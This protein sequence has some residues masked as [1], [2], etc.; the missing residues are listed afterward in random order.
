MHSTPIVQIATTL[1]D[2]ELWGTLG[3]ADIKFRYRRTVIGPFWLTI[4]TGIIV[5]AI[6]LLYAAL[7][8]KDISTYIPFFAIGMIFWQFLSTGMTE[9]CSVFINA[10]SIIKAYPIA[11]PTHVFRLMWRNVIIFMHNVMI[12]VVVWAIFRW[13]LSPV[14]LLAVPGIA[15]LMI[16]MLGMTLF[17]GVLCTRFRDVPLVIGATMQLLFFLTPVMWA[18]A[19]VGLQQQWVVEINPLYG[20]IEVV[21]A[22]LLN[23]VPALKEWLLAAGSAACSLWIGLLFY[24]RH[25][26]RIPYWL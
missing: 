12:I 1:R 7:L 10:A 16:F 20:L 13:P 4:S 19:D 2:R 23:T 22:P 26:R 17:L 8:Q 15:L 24:S 3:W 21:R 5:F 18:P 9:G 6:G 11:L 14:V 25:H